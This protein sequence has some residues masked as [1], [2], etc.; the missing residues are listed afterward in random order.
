MT[1][2]GWAGAADPSVTP[3][4]PTGAIGPDRYVE[5]V[6]L[7]YAIFAR[8]GTSVAQGPLSG[9][10]GIADSTAGPCLSDPQVIWDVDAQRFFYLAL[11]VCDDQ[12]AFGFSKTGSPADGSPS[13]WCRYLGFDYGFDLPDYPKL[14]DSSEF[15]LIGTNV[16]TLGLVYVG[17]DVAWI[18]KHQLSVVNGSCADPATFRGGIFSSVKNANGSDASTPV[19]ANGIDPSGTA[20]VVAAADDTTGP[21]SSLSVFGVTRNSITGDAVLSPP[22]SVQVAVFS[23]P[24]NAPEPSTTKTIDTSDGRLTMAVAAVDPS[25]GGT[26]IWTTHAIAGGAGSVQ[27][28][29]E[30]SPAGSLLRSGTVSNATQ[31]V[32]NGAV[33]PDRAVTPTGAAFGNAMVLGF[34]T[35]SATTAPAIRMV[36]KIG[37]GATSAWVLVH[38][39]GGKNVD[40]SCSPVCRWGD[41]SGASPDPAANPAGTHGAVWLAGEWNVRSLTRSDVDWRTWVWS[42]AP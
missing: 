10:T 14:G 19:P 25:R 29:Y 30:I 26:T 20:Y 17:S 15:L 4:D 22:K 13:S 35:S 24:A 9:L 23:P 40:F 38:K 41:Y 11:D 31:F 7:R 1:P 12:L 34:N 8:D 28:W 18:D 16:F 42:A 6:N 39:S 37:G 3:P 32:F 21:V 2:A 33:S 36:S 5:L 27:R